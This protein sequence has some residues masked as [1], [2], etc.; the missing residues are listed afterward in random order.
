MVFLLGLGGAIWLLY[1][2][3]MLQ[4]GRLLLGSDSVLLQA[5]Y[6]TLPIVVITVVSGVAKLAV[7][8]SPIAVHVDTSVLFIAQAVVLLPI[9]YLSEALTWGYVFRCS[10]C[11]TVRGTYRVWWRSGVYQCP[12]CACSYVKGQRVDA[13]V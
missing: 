10:R 11:G 3:F 5:F 13:S 4:L 7:L 9:C 12:S 6:W 2:A 8:F 1:F